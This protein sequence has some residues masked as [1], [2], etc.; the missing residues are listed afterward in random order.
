MFNWIKNKINKKM[1]KEMHGCIIQN[2]NFV[3]MVETVQ[4]VFGKDI[5]PTI[6]Q[7]VYEIKDLSEK[8]RDSKSPE[9]TFTPEENDILLEL[10]KYCRN[11][12]TNYFKKGAFEFDKE[13]SSEELKL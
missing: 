9:D 12:W 6:L 10:N 13:F 4:Y 11:I 2:L 8:I 3:T 5:E 7:K 1:S